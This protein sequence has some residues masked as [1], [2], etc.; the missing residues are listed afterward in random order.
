MSEVAEAELDTAILHLHKEPAA[1]VSVEGKLKAWNEAFAEAIDEDLYPE[2]EF[3]MQ[4][5]R[6]A[7]AMQ[8][9]E[10][11]QIGSS[12]LYLKTDDVE[13]AWLLMALPYTHDTILAL[14]T[15]GE[16][17]RAFNDHLTGLPNRRDANDRLQIEWR[18]M[19]RNDDKCFSIAMV[20]IDHFKNVNDR[21]GHDIG[22]EVLVIVGNYLNGILR[23]GDWVARWGG[24][25]FLLYL[26]EIDLTAAI[27]VAE[28]IRKTLAQQ[29]WRIST[30]MEIRL[31]ACL[32]VV[33]SDN[34]VISNAATEVCLANMINSADVLLYDAKTSGRNCVVGQIQGE[35]IFWDHAELKQLITD[36]DIGAKPVAVTD[37]DHQRVGS[38]WVMNVRGAGPSAGARV[39]RSAQKLNCSSMLD[40][41]TI[42]QVNQAN[43]PAE[44]GSAAYVPIS[45]NGLMEIDDN[46]ELEA[47]AATA[48]AAGVELTFILEESLLA[49]D[50]APATL[51]ILAN[52]GIKLCLHITSS[53]SIPTGVINH[54]NP[55]FA[56]LDNDAVTADSCQDLLNTLA[57]HEVIAIVPEKF[58]ELELSGKVLYYG[59]TS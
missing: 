40:I 56:L 8:A 5:N 31:T 26:H 46:A 24:E 30:G 47:V 44:H 34:Y 15:Q 39:V 19:L 3:P 9:A 51:E 32:G 42:A 49:K 48:L 27:K 2:M 55:R 6:I 16:M 4:G 21:F 17:Q 57:K 22:D 18:R 36:G 52:R 12:H 13:A 59:E 35:K 7:T 28:R 45:V 58:K 11:G 23:A 41:T 53:S 29:T 43:T 20:D 38:K 37:R 54:L 50:I 10:S 33:C 1:L 25:E 14:L